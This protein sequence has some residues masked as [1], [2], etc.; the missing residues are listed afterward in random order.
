MPKVSIIIP[1]YNVSKYIERCLQSVEAQTIS[2]LEVLLVDNCG[3]DDSIAKAEAF[4]AASKRNDISWRF[5]ATATNDGPSGA[6]NLG[7]QLATGEYVAFLD[8]DDW[9]E[10]QMY[11][12][13]Y[14]QATAGNPQANAGSQ[15]VAASSQ[16]AADLSCC[17]LVQDF[18]DGRTSRVLRNCPMPEG[19]LT[20]AER[21]RL[22]THFVSY[23]TTFIYRREWLIANAII[24]PSTRS[25][26][27]SSFL[28]CCLLAANRIAQTGEPMY[29]YIIHAGSLTQRRVWKGRDKRRAFRMTLGFAKRQ[30]L[31]ATYRRQLR[32]LYI[33]KALLVPVK[34]YLG[35]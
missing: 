30:G 4:V 27:D 25:A 7:I 20:V 12:L 19:E 29:H 35:F 32:F 33:K 16:Q 26:E 14:K 6:R 13:L 21:K 5:A 24:F 2:G 17:N 9:V 8:A 34:E 15:Q 10:P 28:A 11:E 22:L 23:F 18:E 31:Y 1:V 3:T